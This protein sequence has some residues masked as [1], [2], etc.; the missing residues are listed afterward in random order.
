MTRCAAPS[1]EVEM[2]LFQLT[3]VA[4]LMALPAFAQDAPPDEALPPATTDG[5]VGS[6]G[7]TPPS[8]VRQ[9]PPASSTMSFPAA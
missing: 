8:R 4:F 2:T 1:W 3:V 6:R 5:R 7:R 9:T